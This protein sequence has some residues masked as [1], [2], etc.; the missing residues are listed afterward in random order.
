MLKTLD[1]KITSQGHARGTVGWLAEQAHG[2]HVAR[3]RDGC[4]GIWLVDSKGGTITALAI[5][6]YW[7]AGSSDITTIAED[8]SGENGPGACEIPWTDAAWRAV[9][10]LGE[11][12]KTILEAKIDHDDGEG[13]AALELPRSWGLQCSCPYC[14]GK[15][16]GD[17]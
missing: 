7:L 3:T 13:S 12:A 2:L 1:I 9:C 8:R 16:G 17:S 5:R 10:D 15:D 14:E 4:E 11:R 6:G